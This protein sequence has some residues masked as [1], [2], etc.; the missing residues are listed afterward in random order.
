MRYAWPALIDGGLEEEPSFSLWPV[1]AKGLGHCT[2]CC[3]ISKEQEVLS[4]LVKHKY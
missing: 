4:L 3:I 2:L 1:F